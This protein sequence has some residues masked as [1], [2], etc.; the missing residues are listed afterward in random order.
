M[1]QRIIETLGCGKVLGP[2]SG[3]DRYDISVLNMKDI[4]EIIIPFFTNY[5]LYGAKSL[6]FNSFCLGVSIVLRKEHL[7]KKGLDKLK[8]LT[9]SM[10]TFFFL[11]RGK[12]ND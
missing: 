6:D 9:Y 12:K 5:P 7:T 3:R 1:L 4:S 2:Y 11:R 10:N 8:D